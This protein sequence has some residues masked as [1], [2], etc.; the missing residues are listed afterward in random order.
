[1]PDLTTTD[2]DLTARPGARAHALAE[3]TIRRH[4][5]RLC[6]PIG[7]EPHVWVAPINATHHDGEQW[8]DVGPLDA[9]C[10]DYPDVADILRR[11]IPMPH[12]GASGVLRLTPDLRCQVALIGEARRG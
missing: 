4:L 5:E 3:H 6:P 8:L 9:V 10:R 12:F 1:M 11:W 2:P 7:S